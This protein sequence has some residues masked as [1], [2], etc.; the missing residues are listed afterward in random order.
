M[1][2]G[3][4]LLACIVCSVTLLSLGRASV[5]AEACK[6]PKGGTKEVPLFSPPLSEAVWPSSAR[7]RTLAITAS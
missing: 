1:T 2:F 5:R 4:T 7:C 3:K 6:E